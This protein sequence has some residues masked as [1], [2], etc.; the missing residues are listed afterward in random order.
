MHE[1]AFA[2]WARAAVISSG[3]AK[4]VLRRRRNATG[5]VL[6]A[7]HTEA[8]AV[9][10]ARR[11]EYMVAEAHARRMAKALCAWRRIAAVEKRWVALVSFA[12]DRWARRVLR[13]WCRQ[14]ASISRAKRARLAA[15][16]HFGLALRLRALRGWY[17]AAARLVRE[18]LRAQEALALA[19]AHHRAAL[20]RRSRVVMRL[21]IAHVRR[22]QR[23]ERTIVGALK[24]RRPRVLGPAIA[25]WRQRAR[26]LR[27]F[28]CAKQAIAA[29]KARRCLGA[30]RRMA[31]ELRAGREQREA[32]GAMWAATSRKVRAL[33]G[34]ALGVRLAIL[35]RSAEVFARRRLAR[36][37]LL[38]W[39]R[40]AR[41]LRHVMRSIAKEHRHATLLARALRH[42][43]RM[44]S[45]GRRRRRAARRLA[46]GALVEH[47]RRERA[48]VLSRLV[49][50]RW[51]EAALDAR[52]AAAR[53]ATPS[54]PHK[55][56]APRARRPKDV[57]R[58][59]VLEVLAI[60]GPLPPPC[61]PFATP[62]PP[63]TKASP[64][65]PKAKASPSPRKRPLSLSHAQA[66][67]LA[68]R[69]AHAGRGKPPLAPKS[70]RFRR[71]PLYSPAKA[72]NASA[73]AT[74]A[75]PT[76]ARMGPRVRG[77]GRPPRLAGDGQGLARPPGLSR[78]RSS[79]FY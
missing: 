52:L 60:L 11:W 53:L 44:A 68:G 16:A 31:A 14:A 76:R 63:K 59:D 49:L 51:L 58:G 47:R 1:R 23:N 9:A 75:T 8:A 43:A 71:G 42:W 66:Q 45:A 78:L 62:S 57:V 73:K 36:S 20:V 15:C 46:A 65:S 7:W 72:A 33:H 12:R 40:T 28:R 56:G 79:A 17:A 54:P 64:P 6:I 5:A 61:V 70:V 29:R 26:Q 25:R 67:S 22:C 55:A 24:R 41:L 3:L 50:R 74:V 77:D 35:A 39:Q 21:W 19:H 13:A 34:W 18:R 48:E 4:L 30:W 69:R 27:Q 32:R 37:A 38:G 10:L 2:R